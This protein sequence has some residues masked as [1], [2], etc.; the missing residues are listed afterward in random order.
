M[1]K[2]HS[3]NYY[4]AKAVK[5]DDD[6]IVAAFDVETDD[7]GGKLLM[8]QTGIFGE[9]ELDDSEDMI[10]NFIAKISQYPSPVI[11]YAH[12]AQYDWRYFMDAL[13]QSGNKFEVSMRTDTD[14]Y[15]ITMWRE[16]GKKII[17]RDSYALWNSPLEKLAKSL[18]PEIP[19][20]EFDFEKT[21]FDPKNPQHREY[22]KRDVFI[23]LVGLPRLFSLLRKH[24]G[25]NPNGT[26]AS[27]A[28]KGW[29]VDLPADS[30]YN[31][32]P[33]VTPAT[34]AKE[35]FVRQS[36]YGGL[37]FLT[38]TK[39]QDECETIDINSSYPDAMRTHGV[40]YGRA[41]ET[42]DYLD[43]RMGIYHC[44]VRAP[45]DLVIPI[46]PARDKKGNM[47][48]YR[49][50][51]DTVC[52]NRELVFAAKHGYEILK[53]YTGVV[54]EE[55]VFPFTAFISKCEA[56]RKLF[57]IDPA[58]GM[59]PEEWL[60]K[61]MQNSLYGKFG[62]RRERLR[63]IP[64]HLMTPEEMVGA[65]PYDDSGNWYTKKEIDEGMRTLP[66]W[67][68]FI[69]AHA[70]LKLLQAAYTAGVENVIYG[71]TDSLTLRAGHLANLDIG[72]EYGQFK[73][74]KE[75]KTFRA[76]AP[77]VYTGIL[78]NGKKMGAAK[79]LPRKN[80]TDSH[81]DSL[82]RDGT[83]VAQALS[84]ASL[85]VTLKSG[86][87]PATMLLRKSSSLTN[88]TNFMELPNGNVRAKM[89]A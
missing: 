24:F 19:K 31:S 43:D 23:L 61:G 34:Q 37:V 17:M 86:V 65:D 56:M 58:L 4:G 77:K 12:F 83:A 71:D 68:A 84:L 47:R 39:T 18:C 87:K 26:F 1:T 89:A 7:L 28:L 32:S 40:P 27:T 5:G 62:S 30:L 53:I 70:R 75:W 60:A 8:V 63:I 50:E 57:H 22:A 69:T 33:F 36:Y 21:K 15:Q 82:L 14:V 45:A 16:D 13:L 35:L 74:E 44:R 64:A 9:V 55:T 41:I 29:Q 49:G 79:G 76:I 88:S 81:W 80:L 25:I 2:K 59:A 6:V 11:W 51:F 10:P 20:L 46:I 3:I 66:Q 38:T 85:R 73:L 42:R 52:T 54:Y 48:W 78:T 72:N 67:A